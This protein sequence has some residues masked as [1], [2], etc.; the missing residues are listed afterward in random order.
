MAH[1]GTLGRP[2]PHPLGEALG[3]AA[4]QVGQRIGQQQQQSQL[5]Q[6]LFGEEEG[7]Q[8]G[9]Q[10]T[11][12]LLEIARMRAPKAPAG[13]ITGQPVEPE[14][15][16]KLGAIIR[17][18][19]EASAEELLILADE[20]GIPRALSTTPIESR[21]RATEQEGKEK[22]SKQ[23]AIRREVLPI[24]QEIAKKAAAAREG[25]QNKKSL[26]EIIDTGNLDDPT[27][28]ALATSLPL[29]LGQR[30]LSPET[31]EYR[32]GL[33]EEFRDLKNIFQGQTRTAELDILQKKLADVY[34]TDEQK[35]R[36]LKS[37]M[38]ALQRDVIVEEAAAE[39]EEMNP[40]LGI[41]Q[42]NKK[43]D[44]VA[45]PQLD[46]LFDQIMNEHNFVFQQAE[47][48]KGIPLN[49]SDPDDKEILIQILKEA[50]GDKDKARK[51]AISR[52]YKF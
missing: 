46:A 48:R 14:V 12:T 37:R 41:F 25:I 16:K 39:V 21:R 28:A 9:D 29:N 2:A 15:A 26:M 5:A 13:G 11:Q 31:V 20:A 50:S 34:L 36:V 8:L 45:K 22:I 35:K 18:N 17:D 1:L 38:N 27:W 24:K 43:V 10:S 19:P 30:L 7:Q 47:S 40:N 3:M 23:E 33:V 51:M 32:A 4:S 49:P 6:A 52:G 42:F 44:R